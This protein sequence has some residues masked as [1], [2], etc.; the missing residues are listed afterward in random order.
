M[1]QLRVGK[2]FG[3]ELYLHSSWF[4]L[5]A[6]ITYSFFGFFK[7]IVDISFGT[8]MLFAVSSTFIFMCSMLAH[9][10][11]HCLVGRRYGF[12]MKKMTF[13]IFGGMAH[14]EEGNFY[15]IG[16]KAEL[17]MAIAGPLM[18]LVCCGFFYILCLLTQCLPVFAY[19]VLIQQGI[20]VPLRDMFF[21][22]FYLNLLMACFNFIP[23]F[24]MDGGR[25]LRSLLWYKKGLLPATKIA[26][27]IGLFM[28]RIGFPLI[29]FFVFGGLFSVIW[30]SLIGWFILVPACMQE[31][32]FVTE[33]VE[34]EEK[35]KD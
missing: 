8:Q 17:K 10:M 3:I 34:K 33:M 2:I 23:A 20:Y 11:A 25:V 12:V 6:L 35:N 29:G 26:C 27:D 32:K 24:P 21:L 7:G 28:G 30:L 1:Q 18:S 31:V 9:E 16:S 15:K 4:I 5:F 19:S 22:L 13:M 14:L